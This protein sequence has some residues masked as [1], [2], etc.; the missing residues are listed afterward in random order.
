MSI[1]EKTGNDLAAEFPKALL[2]WYEFKKYSRILYIGNEDSYANV[3]KEYTNQIMYMDCLKL[4]EIHQQFE[5]Y[6]DYVVCVEILEQEQ[7]LVG[8]LKIIRKILRPDGVFLAGMNN[9]LGLRYFCGDRDPY[10]CRNFDG[11]EGY[12]RAYVKDYDAFNGRMYSKAELRYML[13]ESGWRNENYQFYSV[14]SDLKNPFLIYAED[15]YP[16]EDLATRVFPTYNY[17]ET[18]F[19]EEESLYQ[20]LIDNDMFHQMANAYLI[21]CSID[22]G[23]SDVNHVTSSIERGKEDA[24]MT[25]IYKSGIVEKRAIY[26]TAKA[27][28]ERLVKHSRELKERG[29]SVIDVKV[30]NDICQMPYLPGESG[31]LYLKKLLLQDPEEFLKKLDY[32]RDLVLHSSKIIEPDKGDGKGAVLQKGY[33]DMIPLNSMYI[34]G[35]FVFFDQEFSEI[36][37]PANVIIF[38]M[39]GSFY[40]GNAMLQKLLP[41]EKLYE[42]YNLEKY[43]EYWKKLDRD[44]FGDLLNKKELRIYHQRFRRNTE[45]VNTNRQRMNYGEAEYE[46]IFV[47]IFKELGNRKLIVFGSGKFAKRFIR[48]YGKDYPVYAVVDNNEKLWGEEIDGITIRM[49]DILKKFASGECKVIICIK[50]YLSVMKQL[51]DMGIYDFSIFDSGKTYKSARIKTNMHIDNKNVLPKKYHVGYAA[52]VFDMFHVGHV[53]LLRKAKE[54]CDYLIVGVVSDKDVFCQKNKYPIIPCE[55]RVEIIRACKYVDQVDILPEN[56]AGIQDAYKMYQF[57]CMFSGDDHSEDIG[58][59]ATKEFLEKNGADIVFFNYT[60][61]V[62]STKLRERINIRENTWLNKEYN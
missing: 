23:L 52:G 37:Y 62:S 36:N 53:N 50:N 32:F 42:R 49:P 24:L 14:L 10:T 47:D 20:G 13:E 27:R 59:V 51:K 8:V 18:V 34:N 12:K 29:L 40:S 30:V 11:I 21:E 58:W 33:L 41:K 56:Y 46:R 35:E 43:L 1:L 6:F 3:L 57:D 5:E 61:K 15:F 38:R 45:I 28:L 2:K 55:D 9:R 48:M 44:F 22:G 31:Q 4:K 60:K 7:D 54:L 17:P 16:N 19:L 26:P 39:I 25:I